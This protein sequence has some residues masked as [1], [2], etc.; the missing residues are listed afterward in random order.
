L[1]GIDSISP[2][3]FA[4]EESSAFKLK[5]IERV[6]KVI[7]T[8]AAIAEMVKVEALCDSKAVGDR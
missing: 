8:R 6:S 7:E 4:F 2:I 1:I 3:L 5:V